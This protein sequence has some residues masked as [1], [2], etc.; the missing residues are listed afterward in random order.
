LGT[1]QARTRRTRGGLFAG[2]STPTEGSHG[3]C[4]HLIADLLMVFK[5]WEVRQRVKSVAAKAV[6]EYDKLDTTIL[7]GRNTQYS[8]T[9]GWLR[10]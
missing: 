4:R 2:D 8:A 7:A 5:G 9:I 6:A 1:R 3:S 10:R